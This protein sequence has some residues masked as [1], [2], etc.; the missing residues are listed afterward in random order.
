MIVTNQNRTEH[1]GGLTFHFHG[2]CYGIMK[3]TLL[4]KDDSSLIYEMATNVNSQGI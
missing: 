4:T 2:K 1:S 3:V